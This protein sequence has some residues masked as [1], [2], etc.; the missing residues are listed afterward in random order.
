MK[1]SKSSLSKLALLPLV[2]LSMAG[3]Q[4][5]GSSSSSSSAATTTTTTTG[6][7]GSGGTFTGSQLNGTWTSAC[8]SFTGVNG[9]NHYQNA[10]TITGGNT[11]YLTQ[12]TYTS[13]A[14]SAGVTA[15]AW[16]TTG[17]F[18]VGGI[19]SGTTQS[20]QFTVSSATG[21]T[22]G[23]GSD[24]S[25]WLAAHATGVSTE[26]G[27]SLPVSSGLVYGYYG[28][29]ASGITFPGPS[30]TYDTVNNVATYSNNVLT[31]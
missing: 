10:I 28:A 1:S 17:T 19:V 22:N 27:D 11:W 31:L 16:L 2:C 25:S 5:P 23:S 30:S 29:S 14:C 3:C 13:S 6:S 8:Y 26:N 24:L 4:F 15:I 21:Q 20:M 18:T 7:G 9:E 12:T